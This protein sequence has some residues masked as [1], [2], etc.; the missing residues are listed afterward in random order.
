[1]ND[2]CC[3]L[4]LDTNKCL[5]TTKGLHN[6]PSQDF[7]TAQVDEK[8]ECIGFSYRPK[9][10]SYLQL[11]DPKGKICH[12]SHGSEIQIESTQVQSDNMATVSG[13]IYSS[14]NNQ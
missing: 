4:S 7:T 8:S 12:I 9:G 1:M 3:Q 11:G 5:V 14:K 10:K 6:T 2:M 13:K